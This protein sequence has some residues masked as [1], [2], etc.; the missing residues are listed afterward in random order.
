MVSPPEALPSAELR[1]LSPHDVAERRVTWGA[2]TPAPVRRESW[3]RRV[4]A[5][6]RDPFNLVLLAAIALTVTTGDH[7]DA[8]VITTVIVA[9]TSVGLV[10]D[11]K[12]VV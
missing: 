1:G 8:V 10:Q 5:Q 3:S 2:N 12:S 11:R 4:V 9:N 7:S 6:L